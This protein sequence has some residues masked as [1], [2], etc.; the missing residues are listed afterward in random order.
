MRAAL[1]PVLERKPA[2][3][4]EVSRTQ[5]IKLGNYKLGGYEPQ[6]LPVSTEMNGL[7]LGEPGLQVGLLRG[8]QV[9]AIADLVFGSG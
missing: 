6:L 7:L 9:D 2:T 4:I 8:T 5:R 1:A 3:K